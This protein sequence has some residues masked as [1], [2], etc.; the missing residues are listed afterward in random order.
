MY[1]FIPGRIMNTFI[2]NYMNY[3]LIKL[4]VFMNIWKIKSLSVSFS[5]LECIFVLNGVTFN[6]TES[7]KSRLLYWKKRKRVIDANENFRLSWTKGIDHFIL[8]KPFRNIS[9]LC[10]EKYGKSIYVFAPF[11]KRRHDHRILQKLNQKTT[12]LKI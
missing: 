10:I 5:S 7:F 8:N 9:L 4:A 11:P 12:T 6:N 2:V 1:N 3:C